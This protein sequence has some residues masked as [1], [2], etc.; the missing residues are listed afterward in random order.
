MQEYLLGELV[1][2]KLPRYRI[3]LEDAHEQLARRCMAYISFCLEEM[4]DCRD[5]SPNATRELDVALATY[6]SSRP[7]MKYVLSDG[8]GH[9]AH[10]GSDNASIVK[11]METLQ[12]VIRRYAWEWDRMC[13]LVPS[14]GSVIPWPSSQHDFLMYSLVA[15]ASDSLFHAFLGRSTTLTPREGTNPLVYAAHF[16]KTDHAGALILRGANVN[17]WGLVVN[18][19]GSDNSIVEGPNTDDSDSDTPIADHSHTY[20]RQVI[21]IQVA[22]DQWHGEMLDLL[23][24]EGST[25]PDVLLTHVLK[26]QPHQFPLNIV[27][28]LLQTPEFIRWAATPWDNRRLLEAVVEDEEDYEDIH[29]RDELVLVTRELIE[30]GYTETLLLVA[31]EKGCFPVIKTLLSTSLPS[32]RHSRSLT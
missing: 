25:V 27:R 16:C 26:V 20:M 12:K 2:T 32:H 8:F 5:R 31:V 14:T 19:E 28:R 30:A 3:V 18:K 17:E 4:K 6:Y 21:P 7:L 13:K 15:F 1:E 10:L 22:V 29:C 11:D 24:A 9:L 23:I